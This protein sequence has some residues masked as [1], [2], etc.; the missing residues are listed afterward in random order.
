MYDR[1]FLGRSEEVSQ[2]IVSF[3]LQ[4]LE[5]EES[6]QVQSVLCVGI[7]KLLLSGQVT[8][9]RVLASLIL[10]YVSP[11]TADNAELRQCLSYFFPLYC[12]SAPENQRRMQSIFVSAFDLA[13]R[14]YEELE[15]DQEMISLN[16]FGLLFVDWTDPTKLL[17]TPPKDATDQNVHADLAISILLALYDSD[18][19]GDVSEEGCR[20]LLT[21]KAQ[22]TIAR[23]SVNWWEIKL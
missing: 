13:S 3:V 4:M 2:Q 14:V 7:C 1:E 11:A 12:Y 18:R 8:D 23:F 10:T 6:N 5:T 9:T 22:M 21:L 17:N 19:T 16:Q 15:E 20:T